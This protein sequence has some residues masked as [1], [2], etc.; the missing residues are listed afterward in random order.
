MTPSA[1]WGLSWCSKVWSSN[2]SSHRL[3]D[4]AQ[5]IP[6]GIGAGW[7]T[8]FPAGGGWFPGL[9]D[10]AAANGGCCNPSLVG[11]SP[12]RL[13]DW[14]YQVTAVPDVDDRFKA[15][16]RRSGVA[17]TECWAE[18]D[19]HVMSWDRA[20]GP[21][22]IP[23][24]FAGGLRES[25]SRTRS[26]SSRACP[27]SIGSPSPRAPSSRGMSPFDR[28]ASSSRRSCDHPSGRRRMYGRGSE[29]QPIAHPT[30]SLEGERF[31]LGSRPDTLTRRNWTHNGRTSPSRSPG[32]ACIGPCTR[33]TAG[34]RTRE[35]AELR[36]DLATG[37]PEVSSDG[38]RWT[39]RLRRG[40]LYAPP[41][42]ETEIIAADL[43]RALERAARVG[44][45][46]VCLLLLGDPRVRRLRRRERGLHRRARDPG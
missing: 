9:F 26:T 42:E 25:R 10:S 15:C 33:T 17:S 34:P 23:R 2:S 44:Q 20:V 31:G 38:L 21:A 32:A 28:E 19:Q 43:V 8:D 40:L 30:N 29:R 16:M 37:I 45:E 18:F 13:K 4:A 27:R 1:S 5:R 6:I 12:A 36:P 22:D 14:G 24:A 3:Y 41:F 7:S 46:A 35:G 11:A 39:F